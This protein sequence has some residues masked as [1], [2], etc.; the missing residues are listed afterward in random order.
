[1]ELSKSLE[2][3][4]N[5]QLNAE[6]YSAYLYLAMAAYLEDEGY[7]GTAHW[8]QV[9][10]KE[11]LSHAMKIYNYLFDRNARPIMESIEKPPA[12]WNGFKH[13]FESALE[14]ERKITDSIY[15]IVDLAHKEGDHATHEF[16]EWFVEEQVEE[17]KTITEILDKIKIVK[18]TEIGIYMIDKELGERKE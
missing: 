17:E 2:D 15:K 1:M 11:E 16:L 7:F 3:A 14:H 5:K 12:Q 18:E 6:L 8:M 13:V 9:Q 10:A 4:L